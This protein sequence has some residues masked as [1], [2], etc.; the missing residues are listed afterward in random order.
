M[1]GP[2]HL[3]YNQIDHLPVQAINL[4]PHNAAHS[5]QYTRGKRFLTA[6][7]GLPICTKNYLQPDAYF[8][9]NLVFVFTVIMEK[10]EKKHC[11]F[12]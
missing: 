12:L 3:L 8:E 11:E 5:A 10:S 2:F 6:R 1:M 9:N 7:Q 4:A